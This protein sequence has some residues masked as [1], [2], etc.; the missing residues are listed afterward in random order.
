M[1]VRERLACGRRRTLKRRHESCKV[2]SNTNASSRP[3]NTTTAQLDTAHDDVEDAREAEAAA[4]QLVSDEIDE[5][6]AE[7]EE[8]QIARDQALERVEDLEGT[9][10]ISFDSPRSH[11][12][13]YRS[14]ERC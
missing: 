8:V 14:S 7:L 5:L 10:G 1:P 3:S 9:F 13:R 2:S 11:S 6:K 12:V 4:A